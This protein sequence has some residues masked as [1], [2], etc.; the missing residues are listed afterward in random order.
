MPAHVLLVEDSR[1]QA[2]RFQLELISYGLNVSLATSGNS[3][4]EA[5]RSLLPDAIVLDVELPEMDGY[6]V[7]RTLKSD[8]R[9]HHIPVVMLTSREQ[10]DAVVTGIRVGAAD[11]IPKDSFAEYNLVEALRQL[12]IM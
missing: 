2:L 5:A 6:N 3:G 9:T 1:T 12:G 11:Y 4:L 7:C 8:P 10:A